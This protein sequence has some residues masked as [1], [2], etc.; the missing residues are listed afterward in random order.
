MKTK[1]IL[2][3]ITVLF[4]GAA[5]TRVEPGHVGIR[6]DFAAGDSNSIEILTN[7]GLY[8]DI[9]AEEVYQFPLFE[10]TYSWTKD[11]NEGSPL[12]ESI[13]FQTAEGVSV[14]T[15]IG[16]T[17][18]INSEHVKELWLTY[19]KGVGEI[20]AG[21]LRNKLRDA[22]N[23]YGALIKVE[24]LIANG[25]NIL[26]DSVT[27]HLNREFNS[28]GILVQKVSIINSI[29]LPENV[30]KAINFKIEA[31]QKAI[32][33]EN[34]LRE[35]EALSKKKIIEA[36]ADARVASIAAETEARNLLLKSRQLTPLIIQ[37]EAIQKWDGKLPQV[38][39]GTS[40][41]FITIPK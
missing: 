13:T 20:I 9:W 17:L 36:E 8:R 5:C 37:Y 40:T 28:K 23:K 22:M 29:R 12:D 34:E 32:A 6:V 35:T 41:P 10:Q 39:S 1:H 18:A 24:D 27:K 19:R 26:A 25:K 4:L 15:D 21:P 16:M 38:S 30:N 31:T 2:S 7:P 11:V 14:N 3:I 33:R